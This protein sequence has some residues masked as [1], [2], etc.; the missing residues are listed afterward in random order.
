MEESPTEARDGDQST[1][2]GTGRG[3]GEGTLGS[4]GATD[5]GKCVKVNRR[6]GGPSQMAFI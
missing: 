4:E 6:G 2:G 3:Q 1:G 5:P